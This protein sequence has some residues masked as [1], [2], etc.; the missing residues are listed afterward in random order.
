MPKA[1]AA[2]G[3]DWRGGRQG[4]AGHARQDGREQHSLVRQPKGCLVGEDMYAVG[5]AV[6]KT[7]YAVEVA[8]GR[9][10]DRCASEAA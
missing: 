8:F 5:L 10:P 1:S 2:T 6:L 3:Y 4:S 7:M 9:V